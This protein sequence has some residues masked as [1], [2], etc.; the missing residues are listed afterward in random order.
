MSKAEEAAELFLEGFNCAQ[1]VLA[2]FC[3][4]YDMDTETA[5]K[6][7]CALGGGCGMAELCGAVSGGALVVGL[8]YGQYIL[9]DASANANCRARR[10]EFLKRFIEKHGSS[11]CRGLLGFD[12]TTDEGAV[13]YNQV[14]SDRASAPC[15]EFVRNVAQILEELG[16]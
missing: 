7:A 13:K 15:V 8:K 12:Y 1:A 2:V 11:T 4:D 5:L 3:E 10:D 6:T 14:F 16:Y 9:E